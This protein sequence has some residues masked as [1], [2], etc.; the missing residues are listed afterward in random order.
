M[1]GA[2][3]E[4]CLTNE[5]FLFLDEMRLDGLHRSGARPKIGLSIKGEMNV[6]IA[7]RPQDWG[8]LDV[9]MFG[10]TQSWEG[11]VSE[12]PLIYGLIVD[13]DRLWFV[14]SHS[15]AAVVHPDAAAGSF[16]R[17]LWKYD[18]VE[19]FI[20]DAK[21]GRYLEVNLAANGAWWSAEFKGSRRRVNAKE[22]PFPSVEVFADTAIE[23]GWVAAISLPLDHLKC[24]FGMDK[25][26]C[27]NVTAITGSPNQ[28]FYSANS[29]AGE[30]PD[31]HQ[32]EQ[33]STMK[34]FHSKDL[35]HHCGLP[36]QK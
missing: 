33:F 7:E 27:M 29:L 10:L 25:T 30:E 22:K 28:T 9:A 18:C 8:S 32:P 19:L 13:H 17:D 2:V 12:A 23:G 26:T 16:Q 3:N 5:H 15:E 14:A 21:T 6:Q 1:R 31:F 20:S 35:P 24:K 36:P 34:L 4:S 11:D